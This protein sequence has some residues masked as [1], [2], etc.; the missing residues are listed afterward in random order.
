MQ[1]LCIE[2]GFQHP[3]GRNGT[4]FRF[5]GE[6]DQLRTANGTEKLY[7]TIMDSLPL[8]LET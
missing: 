6:I 7:F 4:A 3:S 5:L 1:L 8:E 2:G